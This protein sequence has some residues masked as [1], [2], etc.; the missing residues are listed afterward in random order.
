MIDLAERAED[1]EIHL[2]E[3]RP[4]LFLDEVN[5]SRRNYVKIVLS[6]A[7]MRVRIEQTDEF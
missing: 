1:G 3:D 4:C 5:R 6:F 2:N 7:L